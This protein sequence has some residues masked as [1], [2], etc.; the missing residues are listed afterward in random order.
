MR[1]ALI[2]ISALVLTAC[3]A[4]NFSFGKKDAAPGEAE[5]PAAAEE[6]AAPDA[7]GPE[8]FRMPTAEEAEKAAAD[9]QAAAETGVVYAGADKNGTEV[10]LKVGETLRIEL[11]SVPTAGYVWT[12]VEAPAFMEAAGESTRGTDPAHQ[13]LP[14]FT[15]G[16]HYLGFDYVAKAAGTG[17]FKLNEGRPWESEEPPTDTYQLTVT[18]TE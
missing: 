9:A 2:L 3:G 10:S 16:N 14:G 15:G 18:V 13:N 6:E 5:S 7:A 8:E 1:T 11:V 4:L 17:T 12:V